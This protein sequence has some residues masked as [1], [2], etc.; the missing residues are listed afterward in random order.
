MVS[1]LI[2]TTAPRLATSVTTIFGGLRGSG[3]SRSGN[4]RRAIAADTFTLVQ[5]IGEQIAFSGA[6]PLGRLPAALR[7]I[8]HVYEVEPKARIGSELYIQ[9]GL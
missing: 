8:A 6:S 1:R 3:I 5:F 4:S 7:D 2:R 9:N